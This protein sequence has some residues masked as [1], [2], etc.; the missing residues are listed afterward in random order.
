MPRVGKA[1]QTG[2]IGVTLL[3][4]IVEQDLG[5]IFRR[6]SHRD[7]GIDAHVEVVLSGEALG[8]LLALQVKTGAS[9]FSEP[10]P[11][12][13]KYRGDY[14]HLRYWQ[15]HNLRVVVVLVD[16]IAK[17]AYWAF[18]GDGA[19][20][21][22]GAKSWTIEVPRI[23]SVSQ[24]CATAWMDL[25]WAANPRDALYRYCVLH[26][27]YIELLEND[28]R[29]FVEAEDW[30]NKTRGQAKFR[31]ILEESDGGTTEEEFFFFAGIDDVHTWTQRVFPWADVG[32]DDDYYDRHE[33]VEPAAVFHDPESEGG[34][35]IIPGERP[36]GIRPY[37]EGGGGE[38]AYYR[39]ELTLNEI[40]RAYAS[41]DAQSAALPRYPPYYL[42]TVLE[43]RSES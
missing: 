18:V 41:L 14:E 28:G 36:S 42:A 3:Q 32:I 5:W 30:I 24:A 21:Q 35:Y 4:L 16:E 10:T 26:R 31:I 15:E 23:Q 1:D 11:N 6:E 8:L 12:G 27:R 9:Y 29:M 7:T 37:T 17:V 39:F 13:W 33:D 2:A 22:Q 25:A 43:R 19:R 20:I 40:G 34:Y 38:I